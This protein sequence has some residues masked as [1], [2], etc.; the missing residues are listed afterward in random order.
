MRNPL[1]SSVLNMHFGAP[2]RR[3]L[4]RPSLAHSL[5]GISTRSEAYM[6]GVMA[7]RLSLTMSAIPCK[8]RCPD[9]S[10][11]TT[12][13]HTATFNSARIVDIGKASCVPPRFLT[14]IAFCLRLDQ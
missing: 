1:L 14:Y 5:R 12:I 7:T 4:A 13:G 3:G 6:D 10:G 11:R 8:E 9:I 2:P